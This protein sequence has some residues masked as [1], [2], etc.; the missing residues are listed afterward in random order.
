MPATLCAAAY[1]RQGYP[2]PGDRFQHP[3]R[4]RSIRRPL[5]LTRIQTRQFLA[6]LILPSANQHLKRRRSRPNVG[7][8]GLS[9]VSMD[10]QAAWASEVAGRSDGIGCPF[11]AEIRVREI[12][13]NPRTVPRDFPG[14]L[15]GAP[16]VLSPRFCSAPSIFASL[17]PRISVDSLRAT[18]TSPRR[19]TPPPI[20]GPS[21]ACQGAGESPYHQEWFGR[22]T[23]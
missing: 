8:H 11:N 13:D 23:S 17:L 18:G 22:K 21:G 9:S 1:L 14:E 7:L 20:I 19:I 16:S 2:R 15:Q 4:R 5:R 6:A 3:L 12:R 10:N